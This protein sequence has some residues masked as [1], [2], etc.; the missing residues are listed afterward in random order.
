MPSS[1]ASPQL[2][3]LSLDHSSQHQGMSIESYSFCTVDSENDFSLLSTCVTG[4]KG[5]KGRGKQFSNPEEIDRQMKAQ[6]E[7]VSETDK[8]RVR[9]TRSDVIWMHIYMCMCV[10]M[11][12]NRR[13]TPVQRKGA[14]QT[15]RKRAAAKMNLTWVMFY[16]VVLAVKLLG[17][18]LDG[19]SWTRS[20]RFRFVLSVN[21]LVVEWF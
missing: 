2:G 18:T 7:L 8:H 17:L 10:C 11:C 13:Q 21:L 9:G 3:G 5:H 12:V 14:I 19:R 4:K 1:I 20:Y 15:R 16:D 6:R